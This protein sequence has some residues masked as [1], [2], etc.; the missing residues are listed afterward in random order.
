MIQIV[1]LPV[2]IF[3]SNCYIVSCSDTGEGVIVDA[4]DEAD[5]ILAEVNRLHVRISAVLETHAHIDHVS[6]LPE[7]VAGLGAP[8]YMHREEV[9][10]YES[11]GAQAV[12]FGLAAPKRV[13]IGRCLENGER[14]A[15]GKLSALVIHAPGHSPG[16]V[17]YHF[18]DESPQRIFVGDV[19]FRGSIGRTDLPGG[20]YETIIHTL[21]TVFLPLPDE[22]IVY[23]GH[24]PETSVG[25][26]KRFNPFLA[27]LA[28]RSS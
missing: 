5:L 22:T 13:T 8:V 6:A 14:I 17:C 15:V 4:C 7:V 25:Q 23:S 24:G 11:L 20:S 9:P 28:R 2:G 27:P 3:Q 18:A 10:V 26:E 16:S 21:E 1:M 19:L 12:M